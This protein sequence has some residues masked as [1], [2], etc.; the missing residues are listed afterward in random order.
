MKKVPESD[1]YCMLAAQAWVELGNWR[2][3]AK[4]LAQISRP[5]QSAPAVLKARGEV[6]WKGS[7]SVQGS[8]FEVQRF[9]VFPARRSAHLFR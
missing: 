8:G 7:H 6:S 4:E 1:K 9:S 3:A 5:L 2:E